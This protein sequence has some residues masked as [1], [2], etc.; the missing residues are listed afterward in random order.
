[1]AQYARLFRAEVDAKGVVRC[2]YCDAKARHLEICA[3]CVA[4]IPICDS[5][6]CSLLWASERLCEL[7]IWAADIESEE[8]EEEEEKEEP[9][10]DRNRA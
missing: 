10:D 1:M 5:G 8:D 2:Q 4:G 6:T 3:G 7:C 9:G